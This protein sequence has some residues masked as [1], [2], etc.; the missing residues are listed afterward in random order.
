LLIGTF[1]YGCTSEPF[2][3]CIDTKL[4]GP[5]LRPPALRRGAYLVFGL[6][7]LWRISFLGFFLLAFA[8]AL[9]YRAKV[10]IRSL[11]PLCFMQLWAIG[12]NAQ[13]GSAPALEARQMA[14]SE[15]IGAFPES[16]EVQEYLVR[17]TAKSLGDIVGAFKI[18]ANA[19][20]EFTRNSESHIQED[21]YELTQD[22][23]GHFHLKIVTPLHSI[24]LYHVGE[25]VYVRHDRGLL[26]QKRQQV[27]DLAVWTDLVSSS[28]G[29]ALEVFRPYLFFAE[30]T[31]STYQ[32]RQIR[33]FSILLNGSAQNDDSSPMPPVRPSL[34]ALPIAPMARWRKEAK[35]TDLEGSIVVDED[36]ALILSAKLKGKLDVMDRDVRP[37]QVLLTYTYKLLDLG[38]P[39]KIRVP[40]H[41]EEFSRVPPPGD[42]LQ[43]FR[44]YLE[45]EISED[46]ARKKKPAGG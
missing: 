36:T 24:E 10:T 11:V 41:V 38:K 23:Q 6:G 46:T 39:Q 9:V 42:P 4:R 26:R 3:E 17:K 5:I 20:Y 37:T 16:L 29:D 30:S 25:H 43:F 21:T 2:E 7:S 31:Q 12:S 44:A 14:P 45:E 15:L 19:R 8:L 22:T 28:L 27:L 32:K 35:P 33:R 13:T 18:M 40:S 1:C 34:L